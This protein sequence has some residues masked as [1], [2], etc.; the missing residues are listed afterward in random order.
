MDE[1]TP[2]KVRAYDRS[3]RIIE[4]SGQILLTGWVG[5]LIAL[6]IIWPDPFKHAW[7]LVL[8][9]I[10]SGR[11]GSVA[12]GI[13]MG[14]PKWFLL[15]HCTIQDVIVLLLLYPLLVAGY[16]RT[17]EWRI[18]GSTLANIR[19]AAERHKSKVEPYGAIGLMLFVFF[20]FWSTGALAGGFIGYLLGMRSRIV[21]PA[22]IIGEI[23]AVASWIW[24]WDKGSE[25]IF[26]ALGPRAPLFILVGVIVIAAV[27][28]AVQLRRRFLDRSNGN[29]AAEN[30]LNDEAEK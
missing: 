5:T 15:A 2:T 14:F 20:P 8:F 3:L 17:V 18:V 16:R 6:G 25:S 7:G 24:V 1:Q 12:W 9:Q 23:L 30:N 22:V 26:E 28:R 10:G 21:F 29:G 4:R 19:A 27:I 11:A 13:S